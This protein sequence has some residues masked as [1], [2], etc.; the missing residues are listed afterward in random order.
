MPVTFGGLATGLDTDKIITEL[1]SLERRPVERMEA[2]KTWMTNRLA[3]YTAFDS[4][5]SSFHS[6]IKNLDS[7]DVL[8]TKKV[9]SSDE[10][11]ISV[12]AGVDAQAGANYQVEVVSLAQVQKSVSQ[13]YA[14]KSASSFGS[15]ELT[16]T[17]GTEA[18]STITINDSNNSLEGI[19]AAINE[20]DV[21]VSAAIIND[22]TDSPYR[23]VLT[24]ENV[25]SSFSLTSTLP[26]YNGDISSQLMTGGF[27]DETAAY[28][29]GGT[30][31]LST[32]HQ[33]SLSAETNS[34]TSIVE[35]IN[36][37]S[38][39]T[40]VTAS[41]VA[42]GDDFVI[43]LSGGATITTTDLVGG[44]SDAL[45]LTE[46]QAAEQAHIRV[47]NI[48]IYSDSNTLDEAIPGL[49]ID[50]LEAEAGTITSIGIFED[51]QPL[52]EAVQSFVS[53]YNAVVSYVSSQSKIGDSDGGIL[54]GD[55]GLNAVKRRLQNLLTTVVDNSGAFMSLSQLGM[56]TQKD[57]TLSL[58][59]LTL[60]KAVQDHQGDVAKL[61]AGEDGEGGIVGK[62]KD[63]LDEVTDSSI[64]LLAGRKDSIDAGIKRID[65]R[66]EQT[67]LRLVSKETAMRK[68]F[69][70]MEELVSGI[71]NQS[72]FLNQQMDMLTNMMT[73]K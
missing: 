35:A 65:S 72:T 33:V 73:R 22:G 46:T 21:G 24:G 60:T 15:G 68:K 51:T 17:V 1:M 64:G 56:E 28:F 11:Y 42:D 3:A 59:N 31:D 40:G 43:S 45:S 5:L 18:I 2:D 6:G 53:G 49:S 7:A 47:D 61:L 58:D 19:M 63:Y 23:L 27:A 37:E 71:N 39:S 13:G 16:L 20:A 50:L 48:D 54:G 70:A 69:A 32:G 8:H 14:D 26:T 25:D 62:F 66:I 34:L 52:M 12:S 36:A 10:G 4:M 30:L 44:R 55:A 9:T 67:E 41:I 57:G 29:G 38:G